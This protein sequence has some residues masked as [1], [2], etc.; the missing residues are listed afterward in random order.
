MVQNGKRVSKPDAKRTIA[1]YIG[2]IAMG[3]Y[4]NK[5]TKELL[6]LENLPDYK[7]EKIQA[8]MNEYKFSRRSIHDTTTCLMYGYTK[9]QLKSIHDFCYTRLVDGK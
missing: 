8:E 1:V 9:E 4:R 2:N 5:L 3:C 7:V 6:T